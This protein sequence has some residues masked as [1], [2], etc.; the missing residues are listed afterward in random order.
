MGVIRSSKMRKSVFMTQYS[1]VFI[2]RS[3]NIPQRSRN[4][5]PRILCAVS[6]ALKTYRDHDEPADTSIQA[7]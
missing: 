1:T 7:A 5:P 3:R 2:L 4:T 6:L